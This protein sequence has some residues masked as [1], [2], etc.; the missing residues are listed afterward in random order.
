VGTQK[1]VQDLTNH[2]NTKRGVSKPPSQNKEGT[3]QGILIKSAGPGVVV[4]EKADRQ[5]GEGK[6]LGNQEQRVLLP[7]IKSSR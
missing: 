4:G 7:L 1:S 6:R 5:S 3:H 2:K